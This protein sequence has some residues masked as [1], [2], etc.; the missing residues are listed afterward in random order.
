MANERLAASDG[1]MGH[2]LLSVCH[3]HP[4]LD[5]PLK[6]MMSRD[7]GDR[8]ARGHEVLKA[9]LASGRLIGGTVNR[10]GSWLGRWHTHHPS[11]RHRRLDLHSD[12]TRPSRCFHRSRCWVTS[13][14]STVARRRFVR[15]PLFPKTS[16]YSRSVSSPEHGSERALSRLPS[17]S[18]AFFPVSSPASP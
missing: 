4:E 12:H 16:R 2:W 9:L 8:F 14:T 11:G 7:P 13:P 3:A 18:P 6:T 5:I 10:R 1:D 15:T 17:P